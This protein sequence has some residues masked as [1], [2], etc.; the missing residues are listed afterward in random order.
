MLLVVASRNPDKIAELR[1]A[2]AG[3]TLEV[4]SAGDFPSVPE[5][6]ETGL[7]LEENARLK[8]RAVSQATGHLSLADD[9]GLEVD[10]LGG[11]PGVKSGRFAGPEQDYARNV[12]KLLR[13]LEGVAPERRTARFRTAAVIVFPGGREEVAEGVCRGQ[14][15]TQP[16][17]TGGFGYDPVFFVP[18]AGKSFAEMSLEEKDRIS[19]RGRAMRAARAILEGYLAQPGS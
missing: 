4:R 1:H 15:L 6:E 5:V 7:T 12:E 8:A 13:L 11:A 10:A 14:I 16:R 17:G 18:G 3:L 19:H 9:T 2:L